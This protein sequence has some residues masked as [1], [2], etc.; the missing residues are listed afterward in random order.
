MNFQKTTNIS[1]LKKIIFFIMSLKAIYFISDLH[2][3]H[4]GRMSINTHP[5]YIFLQDIKK[6]AHA[7][8][9][10]GDLFECWWGDDHHNHNYQQW[11]QCFVKCPFPIYFLPGNR[12]FLCSK[13]F[14][15]RSGLK[16]ITSGT[17]S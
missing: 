5:F 2:L 6:K 4:E 16:P 3:G 8:Y 1:I 7:L 11:E 15:E 12:D 13:K 17:L 14:F 9:I 10:L